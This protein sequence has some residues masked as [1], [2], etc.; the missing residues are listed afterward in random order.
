[1]VLFKVTTFLVHDWQTN[2]MA[3]RQQITIE[4]SWMN[5][6]FINKD[7]AVTKSVCFSE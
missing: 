4:Y 2:A 3:F 1:M 5:T 7:D 6:K